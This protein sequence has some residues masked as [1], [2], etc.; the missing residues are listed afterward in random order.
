MPAA[1]SGRTFV[2]PK[3]RRWLRKPAGVGLV[4][5]MMLQAI[6]AG[7]PHGSLLDLR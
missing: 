4:G 2:I 5:G 1:D 7:E 6:D 3:Y